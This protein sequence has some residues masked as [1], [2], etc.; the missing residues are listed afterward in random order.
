M[1]IIIQTR[2]GAIGSYNAASCKGGM[3]NENDRYL[4]KWIITILCHFVDLSYSLSC[5][6]GHGITQK[7]LE[8]IGCNHFITNSKCLLS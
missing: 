5:Y 6:L 3:R 1:T 2:T 7:Q 4:R 8:R